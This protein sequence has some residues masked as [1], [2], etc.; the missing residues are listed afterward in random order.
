MNTLKR[1]LRA[2][3]ICLAGA[4]FIVADAS[5]QQPQKPLQLVLPGRSTQ[6]SSLGS[7][8]NFRCNPTPHGE[9]VIEAPRAGFRSL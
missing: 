4:T 3:F 6:P 2:P 8:S 1:M 9:R 7:C 5:A